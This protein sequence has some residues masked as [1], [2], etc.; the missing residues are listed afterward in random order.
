MNLINKSVYL[1]GQVRI[2]VIR[3]WLNYLVKLY[4]IKTDMSALDQNESVASTSIAGDYEAVAERIYIER[5]PESDV[6]AA[7]QRMKDTFNIDWVTRPTTATTVA[8]TFTRNICVE[9]LNYISYFY[10]H[11]PVL[12]RVV[13]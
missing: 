12:I 11:R 4:D 5:A 6:L 10:Y 7:R 9:C 13:G 1:S 2:R 3:Q 8:N